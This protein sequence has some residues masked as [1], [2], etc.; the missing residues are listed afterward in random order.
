MVLLASD[1]DQTRF[2]KASDF[3]T[4]R[5]FRIK[6]VTEEVMD[7]DKAK[8]LVVWFTNDEHGLVVNKTN[9]RILRGAFGDP[10][11]GWTGQDHRYFF[12]NEE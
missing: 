9:N 5:K 3:P 4:P 8:K 2:F 1:Y 11:K 6:D 12:R 10:V 7:Q